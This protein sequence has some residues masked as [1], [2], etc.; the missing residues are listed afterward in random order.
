M[1]SVQKFVCVTGKRSSPCRQNTEGPST[2][3]P[4]PSIY[5]TSGI[6]QEEKQKNL[7]TKIKTTG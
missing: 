5:H 4:P 1:L 2:G 6:M 3:P 7:L